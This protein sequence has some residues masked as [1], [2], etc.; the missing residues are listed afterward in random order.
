MSTVFD[1]MCENG[2]VNRFTTVEAHCPCCKSAALY[3]I[4]K[5]EF[6]IGF[7]HRDSCALSK[8]LVKYCRDNGLAKSKLQEIHRSSLI[9]CDVGSDN[10]VKW[11]F[12]Q[13]MRRSAG[14]GSK[15]DDG[16]VAEG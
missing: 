1:T 5:D 9:Y 6:V 8:S 3:D 16:G 10:F 7:I 11:D 2:T 13:E 15:T 14:D 4:I 12:I